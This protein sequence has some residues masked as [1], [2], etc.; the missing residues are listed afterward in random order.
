M[1]EVNIAEIMEVMEREILRTR[2][3]ISVYLNWESW[4]RRIGEPEDERERRL[5]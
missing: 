1:R 3:L 4:R 5:R 2:E